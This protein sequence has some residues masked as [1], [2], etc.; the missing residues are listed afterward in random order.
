MV[1][2]STVKAIVGNKIILAWL[3]RYLARFAYDAQQTDEP[4]DPHHPNNLWHRWRRT[5]ALTGRFDAK[6]KIAESAVV[7]EHASRIVGALGVA[8]GLA[9]FARRKLTRAETR[10]YEALEAVRRSAAARD[11]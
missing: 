10:H 4:V 1:E 8:A 6:I 11:V 7:G 9:L 2:G 5:T 3:D